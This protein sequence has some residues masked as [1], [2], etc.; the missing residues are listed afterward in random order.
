MYLMWMSCQCVKHIIKDISRT[1][2]LCTWCGCLANVLNTSLN[3]LAGPSF[4]V[5][6]VDV[7]PM[8]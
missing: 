1:I 5:L 3:T 8:C 4:Y 2:I 6:G 7:L